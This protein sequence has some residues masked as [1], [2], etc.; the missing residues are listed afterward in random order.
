MTTTTT[1]TAGQ[2][3]SEPAPLDRRSI[4]ASLLGGVDVLLRAV[5]S[6]DDEYED[7]DDALAH[8]LGPWL[9][10]VRDE[11]RPIKTAIAPYWKR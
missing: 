2:A 3:G 10:D 6:L 7:D 9:D 8:L 11:M 4:R 1:D 5:K